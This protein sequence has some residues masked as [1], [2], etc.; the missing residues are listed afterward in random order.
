MSIL[1]THFLEKINQ[2][3]PLEHDFTEVLCSI[4]LV[5]KMLYYYGIL[6]KNML[7][8]GVEKRPKCVAIVGSRKCTKYGEEVAY[9]LAYEVAKHGGVVIS[10]LAYGIDTAAHKG[11]V[12]AG[13]VTVAVL[14]TSIDQI[15]PTRN[16]GLAKE[17]LKKNG[18]IMSEYSV[19]STVYPR[20]SFLERNRLISGLADVVVVVEAAVKSGAL[21]T[22]MHALEQGRDLFAVPGDITRPMSMGCNRLIK[23]GAEPYTG[24]QD[25]LELLFPAK[26]R[27]KQQKMVFGDTVEET[28]ILKLLGDGV[29][30][31]EELLRQS[32]ISAS[33]FYQTVTMLEI[34]G[35]IKSLGANRWMIR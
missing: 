20:V 34:K 33:V 26:K 11:A 35:M 22:A 12:D 24:V 5:P 19:G 28:V 21:N 31:G 17:I 29:R 16:L 32:K 23:Q 4:A 6:P 25:V 10:G 1:Y 8:N 9:K 15:Q 3:R 30:N 13:G 7:L 27:I 18:C 14:G 2:V